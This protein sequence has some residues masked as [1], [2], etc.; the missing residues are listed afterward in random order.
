M[1]SWIVLVIFKGHTFTISKCLFNL[2]RENLISIAGLL[3]S[4]RVN[5]L[6]LRVAPNARSP[7]A[8]SLH[9][10]GCEDEWASVTGPAT[11]L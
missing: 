8:G 5:L 3:L 2:A 4:G 9:R 1:S 7:A 10:A 11:M 6:P